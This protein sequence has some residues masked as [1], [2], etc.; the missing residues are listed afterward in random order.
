M[1]GSRYKAAVRLEWSE[2]VTVLKETESERQMR[3]RWCRVSE[4]DQ[5][6]FL[7]IN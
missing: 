2:R 5:H 7:H 1:A 6:P 4:E 3:A